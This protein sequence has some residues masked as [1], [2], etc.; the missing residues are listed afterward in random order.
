MH[1]PTL[2]VQIGQFGRAKLLTIDDVQLLED[3][4]PQLD[5][6]VEQELCIVFFHVTSREDEFGKTG[7]GP[8]DAPHA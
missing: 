8:A 6:E 4:Q 7:E 5:G 2:P 1:L 3:T